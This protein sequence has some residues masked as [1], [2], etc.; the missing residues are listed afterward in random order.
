MNGDDDMV[1][2]QHDLKFARNAIAREVDYRRE[3]QWRIFSWT[4]TLLI[5]SIGGAI[6]LA[7]AQHFS[8]PVFPQRV[9]MA[10]ALFVLTS[11]A[12]TWVRRNIDY[13]AAARDALIKLDKQL[14]I[15]E[16]ITTNPRDDPRWGYVRAL[17]LL[18]A[19]GI[20]AVL[21]VRMP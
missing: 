17:D 20:M 10:F 13:E 4:S 8:F 14:G 2:S 6:A 15:S 19:A 12:R 11:Y 18:A 9:L 3:K 21:F 16:S 1:G 7:G 5:A